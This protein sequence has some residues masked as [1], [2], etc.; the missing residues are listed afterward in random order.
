MKTE[1]G[2]MC[3]DFVLKKSV[4]CEYISIFEMKSGKWLKTVAQFW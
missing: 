2:L 1:L 3:D 4:F